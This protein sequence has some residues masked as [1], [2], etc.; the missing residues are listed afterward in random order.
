[1]RQRSNRSALRARRYRLQGRLAMDSK[2]RAAG[3]CSGPPRYRLQL[4]GSRYICAT[5]SHEC[6]IMKR[7]LLSVPHMGGREQGYVQEA[8]SSNWLST[9]GPHIT[10]FEEQVSGRLG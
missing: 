4:G 8:F 2:R 7:I 5:A 1:H 9:V 3:L 6:G 10:A